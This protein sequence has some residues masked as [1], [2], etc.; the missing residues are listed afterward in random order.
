MN[1]V[2][3]KLEVN[4]GALANDIIEN[5]VFIETFTDLELELTQQW[6]NEMSP[7]SRETIWHQY[8]ALQMIGERLKSRVAAGKMASK[9]LEAGK[10]ST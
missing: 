9:Q 7:Q 4:L 2:D 6:Q 5:P 1:N 10:K 3:L 8:Q